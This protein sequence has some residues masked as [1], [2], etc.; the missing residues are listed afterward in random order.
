M[1]P[2]PAL[3][4][5]PRITGDRRLIRRRAD[6]HCF[7]FVIAM[8]VGL[9]GTEFTEAGDPCR[10]A[11]LPDRGE[12]IICLDDQ[13]QNLSLE[14]IPAANC[15]GSVE[16]DATRF[17]PESIVLIPLP[18]QPAFLVFR[19]FTVHSE[20]FIQ[21]LRGVHE[22]SLVVASPGGGYQ[23]RTNGTNFNTEVNQRVREYF[24]A[25]GLF[26]FGGNNHPYTPQLFFDAD[27]GTLLVGATL[28]DME[29]IEE[30]IEVLQ[31]VPQVQFTVRLFEATV[32]EIKQ[33]EPSFPNH[34]RVSRP[35]E[36][37]FETVQV[38]AAAAAHETLT[39]RAPTARHISTAEGIIPSGAQTQILKLGPK[40]ASAPN[41]GVTT[42]GAAV[43]I[44]VTIVMLATIQPDGGVA[45]SFVFDSFQPVAWPG[46]R[47]SAS[48]A[49]LTPASAP[50][51]PIVPR[52]RE[53]QTVKTVAIPSGHSVLVA[54]DT[55][56]SGNQ[57]SA[58]SPLGLKLL[59]T[60][61]IVEP[62]NNRG[63]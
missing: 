6:G 60:P 59:L 29:I 63:R 51:I 45:A 49:D 17:V 15:A 40:P 13:C 9:L 5:L 54:L 30:A 12:V 62:V 48:A 46:S 18:L 1:N 52:Y 43:P 44:R 61:V 20:T 28:A 33:P 24:A 38:L 16:L 58:R 42:N 27:H 53:R 56:E 57:P 35:A 3:A 39:A 50:P 8:L 22:Q 10:T 47:A 32:D 4:N 37:L 21:G 26:N 7:N 55:D 14:R 19:R 2:I 31:P 36:R 11:G 41:A 34:G 23:S 25:A